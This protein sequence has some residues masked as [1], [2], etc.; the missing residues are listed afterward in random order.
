MEKT[1]NLKELLFNEICVQ[2]P[3]IFSGDNPLTLPQ[4]NLLAQFTE[5]IQ[6]LLSRGIP[7]DDFLK[8]LKEQGGGPTICGHVFDK[9]DFFYTCV[10]C[11]TDPTCVFCKECFFRSTH[12]KH[13]YKMFV[14]G[15]AGS[16]DCGDIEAWTKDP[17]CDVHKPKIQTSQSDP[18]TFLPDWLT[19]HGHEFCHFIFEYAITLQICKDWKTLCP[20]F[21]S[22][23]QPFFNNNSYCVV[24]MN[25]EVNT[26]DDVAALFVKELGIPHRDSLTLTYAIDKLGRALVRQDNQQDCIST[27]AR[28]SQLDSIAIPLILAQHQQ[29]SVF[30]LTAL[31]NICS[32]TPGLQKLCAMVGIVSYN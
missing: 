18:L 13:L 31:L 3:E 9:G 7:I 4:D 11:R 14:S 5:K 26:F 23:L 2:A 6:L 8:N 1:N 25:D 10:E 16:C 19:V 29:S 15:G 20:E 30:L 22:K 24:V 28:L 32:Q 27:T 21:K 12:V 17:H